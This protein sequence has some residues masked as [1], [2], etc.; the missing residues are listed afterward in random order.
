MI[1]LFLANGFEEI[2]ALCPLD[3]LRRAGLKVTTVGIGGDM[4]IGSHGIPVQ[5]DI[6]ETLY[7][8]AKPEMI[9]LPGGMPGS[10]HLD[11]SRTVDS[12]LRS[13]AANGAYLAAIC[14]APMVLG[15]RGYLEGK[16][17]TCFPGFEEHLKGAILP[18]DGSRVIQDGK[19]ITAA[20]MG[21]A[22]EF[23]LSLVSALKGQEAADAL[24]RAVLAD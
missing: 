22:L 24:R 19:V 23:G 14:A 1:Y 10:R 2:E 15:K 5:A 4:I 6:P 21:V 8:D 17:A 3:L 9:I 16:K 12:A 7:R 13:A 20:G 11:E 18:T